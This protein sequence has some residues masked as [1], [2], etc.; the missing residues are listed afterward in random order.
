MPEDIKQTEQHARLQALLQDRKSP[1]PKGRPS[2]PMAVCLDAELSMDLEDADRELAAAKEAVAEAEANADT[3]AGGKVAVDPDLTKRVKDAEKTVAAAEKLVDAAS[4]IVTFTALK[5][6]DYD[7]LKDQH[8]PR[9]GNE[10]DQMTEYNRETFP[11]ALMAA[12]AL[13]KVKD[14]D[15]N[16]VDMDVDEIIATMSNG[17]RTMACRVSN[18]LN[19]RD[20]TFSEA[21]SRNRQRSGSNSNR[22]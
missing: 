16:L 5:A 1:T 7:K 19:L 4:V 12:S 14:A 22:R 2:R 20:S 17:E 15:G 11:D 8:P 9:E 21:N 6:E 13:R 3:R 18:D 10:Y